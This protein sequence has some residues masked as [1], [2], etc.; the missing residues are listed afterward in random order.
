MDSEAIEKIKKYADIITAKHPVKMII[1]YG[2]YAKGIEKKDSDID[3]AVVINQIDNKY[4][5]LT[6]DLYKAVREVDERIEPNLIFIKNNRSG[7]LESILKY[8]KVIYKKAWF[9]EKTYS[10]GHT[11]GLFYWFLLQNSIIIG[12]GRSIVPVALWE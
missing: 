9:S 12:I 7:F 3:V 2:S 4:F 11:P 5:E 1:L 6:A 8:G 10:P